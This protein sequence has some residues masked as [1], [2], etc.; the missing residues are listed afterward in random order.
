MNRNRQNPL[1]QRTH[2]HSLGAQL[3]CSDAGV[4]ALAAVAKAAALSQLTP[5]SLGEKLFSGGRRSNQDT[6]TRF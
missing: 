6:V 2:K 3:R 4:A 1:M 5:T